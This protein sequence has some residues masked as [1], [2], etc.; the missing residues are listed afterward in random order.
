MVFYPKKSELVNR[1]SNPHL[2][3]SRFRV[4]VA[5]LKIPVLHTIFIEVYI[6]NRSNSKIPTNILIAFTCEM[7]VRDGMVFPQDF[8]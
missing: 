8:Y 6:I 7:F 5:H 3:V 2:S 4:V 1:V